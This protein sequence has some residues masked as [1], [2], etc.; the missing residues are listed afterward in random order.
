MTYRITQISLFG[1]IT[2]V[3]ANAGSIQIGGPSGI[4]SDYITQNSG[5]VCAAGAG[6]CITGSTTGWAEK[7][8]NNILFAGA[9]NNGGATSPVPFT[10]YQQTGGE[11]S[12]L[13]ASNAAGT[14]FAMLSDGTTNGQRTGASNNYW[15]STVTGG[16]QASITIPI[17]IYDVTD[18][19]TMLNNQWGTLGGNDTTVTFNF[20]DSS[21]A[22][23]DLTVLTVALT[24][25]PN[26]GSTPGGEIRS[27]AACNLVTTAT[28]NVGTNPHGILQQG[29]PIDGVTVNT[30]VVY[31]TFN[32]TAASSGGFYS[33]TQGYLRLDSQQ[34]VFS[35]SLADLYLVSMTVTENNGNN[36][37]TVTGGILPSETAISAITVDSA[38]PEPGSILL[39][40]S[41]FA[42]VGLLSWRRR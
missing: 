33:G 23:S 11:P 32:Y 27:V 31:N 36:P 37:N 20:G 42:G 4:T 22:T 19:W 40:L 3:A 5:A 9:T 39:M 30:S 15:E 6:N 2:A 21:K 13:T 34:F 24:N 14:T 10:G 16:G 35:P 1:L 18:F 26:N 41:G 12:G 25:S 28:C 29:A 17:G 7:N 8:Y 38:A